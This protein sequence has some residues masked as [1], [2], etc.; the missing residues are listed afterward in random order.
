LNNIIGRYDISTMLLVDARD[1]RSKFY[2]A[3]Q[4]AIARICY[5]PSVRQ[6]VDHRKTVEVRSMTFSPHG[7]QI[8]LAFAG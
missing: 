8:P 4:H 7:S 1:T 5:R 6:T 2:Y 3:R